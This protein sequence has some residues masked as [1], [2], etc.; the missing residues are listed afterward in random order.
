MNGAEHALFVALHLDHITPLFGALLT[1]EWVDL[2][3]ISV[4]LTRIQFSIIYFIHFPIRICRTAEFPWWLFLPSSFGRKWNKPVLIIPNYLPY[5]WVSARVIIY[6]GLIHLCW[7]HMLRVYWINRGR[8]GPA[9]DTMPSAR[10]S[11]RKIF[12]VLSSS[13]VLKLYLKKRLISSF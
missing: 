9:L 7:T 1:M 6:C 3:S 13:H 5:D 10:A 12:S 11:K 4:L 2:S 8:R